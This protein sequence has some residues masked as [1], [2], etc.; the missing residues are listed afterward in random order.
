MKE[1]GEIALSMGRDQIS[2]L[3][4]IHTLGSISKEDQMD[5]DS[6]NGKMEVYISGS[7]KKG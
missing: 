5:S 1:N 4:G 2:L 3:M 7:L 6:I